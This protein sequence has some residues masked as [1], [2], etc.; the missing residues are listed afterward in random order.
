MQEFLER[1]HPRILNVFH[2]D[3]SFWENGSKVVSNKTRLLSFLYVYNGEGRLELDGAGF[4]LAAGHAF[5]IP[6]ARYL[7]LHSVPDSPL[8]YYTVQ[9]EFTLIDWETESAHCTMPEDKVLPYPLVMPMSDRNGMRSGMERLYWLWNSKQSGFVAKTKLA[10]LSLLQHVHEQQNADRRES[11]AERAIRKSAAYIEQ[12]YPEPLDRD[13]LARRV[14]LSSSYYSVQFRQYM[15]CTPVQYI[16]RVRMDKAMQLLKESNLPVSE[17]ARRVGY[18][19]ALYFTRV[20]SRTVGMT[21]R[22]YR[23]A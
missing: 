4:P 17:V 6:F 3:A 1:F 12:H 19:D 8:C 7:V 22:E 2:R 13:M 16:T 5:Q 15:G 14:S 23:H 21:P 20:F 11:E 10:F 18:E 9:Y